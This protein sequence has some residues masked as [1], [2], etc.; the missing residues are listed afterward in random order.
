MNHCGLQV[1]VTLNVAPEIWLTFCEQAVPVMRALPG[2]V[3]KL[4]V[5]DEKTLKAGGLYLF[6]DCESARVYAEG[7]VLEQLRRSGLVKDMVVRQ[8]PLEDALS[9]LT[10]GLPDTDLHGSEAVA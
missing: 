5:L 9:R 6:R 1:E 8:L 4:W 10:W 7:P 3:W 2:L